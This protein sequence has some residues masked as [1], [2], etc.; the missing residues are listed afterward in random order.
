[1][2]P[3]PPAP[4]VFIALIIL[5]EAF[6]Q[7]ARSQSG[8]EKLEAMTDQQIGRFVFSGIRASM[9]VIGEIGGSRV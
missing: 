3:R 2:F 6:P 5:T 8:I 9:R 4:V 1:M 7:S